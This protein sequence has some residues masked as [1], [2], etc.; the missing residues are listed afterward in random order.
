MSKAIDEMERRY[1][2]RAIGQ[3]PITRL[4]DSHIEELENNVAALIRQSLNE[5]LERYNVYGAITE[6][7]PKGFNIRSILN[8]MTLSRFRFIDNSQEA[9]QTM[10][11]L[12]DNPNIPESVRDAMR[13]AFDWIST[14]DASPETFLSQQQQI[15]NRLVEEIMQ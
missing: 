14:Y 2:S 4:T 7:G 11:A 13:K 5:Q 1:K 12:F 10:E 6:R 8:Q 15:I 3:E 9:W